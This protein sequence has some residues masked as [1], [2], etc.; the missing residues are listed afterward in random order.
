MAASALKKE[1]VDGRGG[2]AASSAAM[3]VA[4]RSLA[5]T[6]GLIW[7]SGRDAASS[8]G[9]ESKSFFASFCSQKEGP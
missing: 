1:G 6:L 5:I 8:P 9:P 3:T 7:G 2:R 4:E